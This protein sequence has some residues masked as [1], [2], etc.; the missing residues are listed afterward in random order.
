LTALENN[1]F[2]MLVNKKSSVQIKQ[3]AAIQFAK[4]HSLLSKNKKQIE[5]NPKRSEI[6]EFDLM[7]LLNLGHSF[8]VLSN[9]YQNKILFDVA[10][11][12]YSS[13]PLEPRFRF[14][15]NLTTEEIIRND[16]KELI[17]SKMFD[18]DYVKEIDLKNLKKK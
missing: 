4:I 14:Y 18:K 8:L 13:V 5:L 2:E 12:F 15:D 17:K 11:T 1:S 7:T 9:I 10:L 6:V 3:D 16:W